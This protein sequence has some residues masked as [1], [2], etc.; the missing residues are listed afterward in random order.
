MCFSREMEVWYRTN[1]LRPVMKPWDRRSAER[2]SS[3]CT[4]VRTCRSPNRLLEEAENVG[5]EVPL[6]GVVAAA[7]ADGSGCAVNSRLISCVASVG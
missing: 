2:A 3:V 4:K 6:G 7:V 1:N 5:W